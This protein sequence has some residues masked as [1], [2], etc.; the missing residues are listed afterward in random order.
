MGI[1]SEFKTFAITGNVVDMA[2][3]VIM[4]GAFGGVVKSLVDEIL[5]PPI[6]LLLGNVNFADL[7]ITL[8]PGKTPGPYATL[9][10]AKAA[11]ASVIGYGAFINVVVSFVLVAFAVFLMVRGVNRMRAAHLA[12]DAAA[13][14]SA[15]ASAPPPAPPRGE[16]L[17]EEIRDL[18]KKA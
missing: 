12:A 13:A 7:F 8:S 11:G 4:G 18:L 10:A 14:A 6:G 9:A 1:V 17:L 15:A 3:G 2:V 5:M 16:A